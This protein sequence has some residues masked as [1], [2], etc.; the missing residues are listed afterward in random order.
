MI[1]LYS[2]YYGSL[3]TILNLKSVGYLCGFVFFWSV[4]G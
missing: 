1:K 2:P 3:S 4:E